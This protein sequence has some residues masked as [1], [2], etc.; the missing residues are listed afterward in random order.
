[1]RFDGYRYR[2]CKWCGGKGCVYCQS[3]ADKAYKRAFPNGPEPIATFP[4][5]QEGMEAAR[6]VI[7]AEA[8]KKAFGQGGGGIAEIMENIARAALS[9]KED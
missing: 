8:M 9:Q 1:M 5:T 7:G 4:A 3:E 2:D 6:K